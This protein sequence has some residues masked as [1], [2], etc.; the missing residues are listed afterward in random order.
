ML[1]SNKYF[2]FSWKY[3]NCLN[4]FLNV[5][6]VIAVSYGIT[7][8]TARCEIVFFYIAKVLIDSKL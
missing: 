8:Q 4:A 6:S 5:R 1:N 2:P 7:V 3:Q